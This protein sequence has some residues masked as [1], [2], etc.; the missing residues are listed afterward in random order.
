MSATFLLAKKKSTEKR[1]SSRFFGAICL[2]MRACS[3]V[4]R[5]VQCAFLVAYT[6]L[7]KSLCRSDTFQ[8]R[9]D[10]TW[11][12]TRKHQSR[13]GGQ[14]QWCRLNGYRLKFQ[15]PTNSPTDWQPDCRVT[16]W[17]AC[18]RLKKDGQMFFSTFF[19]FSLTLKRGNILIYYINLQFLGPSFALWIRQFISTIPVAE[20]ILFPFH[21]FSPGKIQIPKRFRGQEIL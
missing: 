17:V 15:L 5:L 16:Y 7:S 3:P 21:Y 4:H 10:K 19:T 20:R 13:R 11:P 1:R 18:R 2:C 12:F 8:Q 9:N 14:G 6:G